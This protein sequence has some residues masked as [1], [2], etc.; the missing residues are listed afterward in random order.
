MAPFEQPIGADLILRTVRDERDVERFAAFHREWVSAAE[1]I[2]CAHLLRYHPEI[3]RDDFLLVE[4][5]RTGQMVSTLCLIPWQVCFAGLEL[6]AAMLEMVLTHPDYRQRGLVRLQ[7]ER[8]HRMV[9][10]RGFDLSIIEGI[11]YYYPQYGYAYAC[12]HWRRESLPAGRVPDRPAG[13]HI[14]WR[15]RDATPAD[16]PRLVELY[17]QVMGRLDVCT[18]RSPAFWH[19]LLEREA[20]PVRVLEADGG[21]PAQGYIVTLPAGSAG[22]VLVAE[23]GITSRDAALAALRLL[24][25]EGAS[26]IQLG[27]PETSALVALGRSL[28][29]TPVPSYQWLIRLTDLPALLLKLAPVFAQRLAASDCAGLSAN[30]VLNL[31]RRAYALDFE[32]GRLRAVRALGFVDSSMGADGGDLCIPPDALVCLLMG[33]RTLDELRDAW[34]DIVIKPESRRVL[35]VLFPRLASYLWMPYLY[36]GPVSLPATS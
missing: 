30:L 19:F 5:T 3:C 25:S 17:D 18:V 15:F 36:Y 35:D 20:Y 21:G 10:E 2:S 14:P 1:G 12:D 24:K 7:I 33:Y 32:D 22:S 23:S 27:W 4:D 28:G 6:R 9:E 8:F 11:P 29:S 16:V 13:S 26:E 34:P 31:F